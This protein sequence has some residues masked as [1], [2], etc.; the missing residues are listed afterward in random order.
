[1]REEVTFDGLM[2]KLKVATR[3]MR[4][5]K[6]LLENARVAELE[7]RRIVCDIEREVDAFVKEYMRTV[8]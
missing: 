5:A 1:M 3:A 8:T 6:E 4:E 2:A 7:A